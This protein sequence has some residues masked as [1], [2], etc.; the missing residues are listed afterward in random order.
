[1]IMNDNPFSIIEKLGFEMPKTLL[2]VGASIGQELGM[3]KQYGI[4]KAVCIEAIPAVYKLLHDNM[5]KYE[6]Y[7]AINALCTAKAQDEVE[8]YI[9]SNFGQSSSIFAPDK[10]LEQYPWVSFPN[11]VKLNSYPLDTVSLYAKSNLIKKDGFT[12]DMLF[13]DTQGAELEVLKGGTQL[14][15]EFSYIYTEI[16]TGDGYKN[17]VSFLDLQNF[18]KFWGYELQAVDMDKMGWGNALFI[19]TN[20]V[21]R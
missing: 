13:M 6:D 19:N 14:L 17:S 8:L 10:H 2:Q 21:K 5:K 15:H 20:N 7:Y 1:M 18:L 16:G 12:F 9:S 3:F 4:E 11:V